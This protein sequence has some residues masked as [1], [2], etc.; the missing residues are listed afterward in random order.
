MTLKC[1]VSMGITRYT[2]YQIFTGPWY[3]KKNFTF[4]NVAHFI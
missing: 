4:F 1:D 3:T 2:W